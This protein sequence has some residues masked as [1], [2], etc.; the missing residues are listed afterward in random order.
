[1]QFESSFIVFPLFVI[2]DIFIST[3]VSVSNFVSYFVHQRFVALIVLIV[4]VQVLP[5]FANRHAIT[6]WYYDQ[7][8]RSDAVK[9]AREEGTSSKLATASLESQQMAKVRTIV[10]VQYRLVW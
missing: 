2:N 5:T 9:R 8:E 1:V 7:A 3:A 10:L 6:L 4:G